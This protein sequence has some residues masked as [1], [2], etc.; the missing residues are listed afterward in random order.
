MKSFYLFIPHSKDG[1]KCFHSF[2]SSF[3]FSDQFLEL[4]EHTGAPR[5]ATGGGQIAKEHT[6]PLRAGS[7]GRR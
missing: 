7:T 6:K 2:W 1:K 3:Q 5:P 4:G